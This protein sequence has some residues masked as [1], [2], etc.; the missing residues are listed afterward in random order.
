MKIRKN[1]RKTYVAILLIPEPRQ[2]RVSVHPLE[3]AFRNE[4]YRFFFAEVYRLRGTAVYCGPN[5][6]R[7]V[8]G[9]G[10]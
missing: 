6:S 9:S 1:W 7:A 5:A 2:L 8:F 4:S 10:I 3:L